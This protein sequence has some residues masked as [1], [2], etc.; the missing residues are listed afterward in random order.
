M[1]EKSLFH[2]IQIYQVALACVAYALSVRHLTD[3]Y[4]AFSSEFLMPQ[5]DAISRYPLVANSEIELAQAREQFKELNVA[6]SKEIDRVVK[7]NR[8][9]CKR[10]S[11][12]ELDFGLDLHLSDI[13]ADLDEFLTPIA[14]FK[15][16][17]SNKKSSIPDEGKSS[18]VF[19]RFRSSFTKKQI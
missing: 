9:T 7:T 3:A 6:C 2:I 16:R 14:Q 12:L 4:S 19:D 13:S 10:R 15:G 8:A 11:I 1:A 18:N 5:M 17:S